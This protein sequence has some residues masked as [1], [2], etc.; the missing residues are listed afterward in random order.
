MVEIKGKAPFY[1]QKEIGV[2]LSSDAI[3]GFQKKA[4]YSM[5]DSAGNFL[6]EFNVKEITYITFKIEKHITSMYVEPDASYEIII[7]APDSTTYQ[8]PNI[9]HDV[10]LSIKLK[11]KTE[12]N[13]LTMDYEK[14]FDEFL[15]TEYKAFV[16]RTPQVKLDS[17]KNY[18]KEY[19]STV[20]NPFFSKYITYTIASLEEKTKVSEKKLFAS[21]L[22]GKAV[23]YTHPEY[24]NFFNTFYKQKLQL[25]SL[26]KEG[27]PLNFQINNRGSYS[28]SMEVL[29][30][31]PF[32][33]ND[34][35]RELVL[36]K[37][38]KESY[39]TSVFKPGSISAIL[40]QISEDSKIPEHKKIAENIL[41]SFSRLKP[42]TTSPSFELPDKE[43]I[44]HSLEEL[45]TKKYVYLMF[46]E[47]GCTSCLQQMK[48]IPALKKQYGE[49]IAFVS[50]SND[51]TNQELKNFCDKNPKYDW[52]FL[53]DNSNGKLRNDF[54]M[55]SLPAYY[56][57]N[58]D[59]KFVQ[60]PAE[61]P[62]EEIERAFH[63]ITKPKVKLHGIG[64]KRNN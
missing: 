32:L 29:K 12:I 19:Y 52:T 40:K 45:R 10:K 4:T 27:E 25:F 44:T 60:I 36:L 1:S 56:L 64:D 8:N 42:G 16:S 7:L 57:I 11:S 22:D 20:Q 50:V 6:I 46:F 15:S 18:I 35:I 26:S 28:G 59:G 37:G 49:Q 3:S 51:K 17:F 14:R 62:D 24:M 31:D 58:P 5:I 38:L 43:G 23:D 63:D 33:K 54:E 30:R 47:A 9:E 13:A 55:R 48:V 39:Y 21:Y 41:S 53:Y 2:W 61:A 34:T